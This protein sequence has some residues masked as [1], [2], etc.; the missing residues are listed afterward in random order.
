M[1]ENSQEKYFAERGGNDYFQRNLDV[2]E[3]ARYDHPALELL[4]SAAGNG[5][6]ARGRATVVGGAGGRE[7][8]ARQQ[9]FPG[10]KVSNVDISP[11]A[12]AFG[13]A[14][15]PQVEHHC[16]SITSS[17]PRL[18][19]VLGENDLLFV[20]VVLSWVDRSG[21]SRA[22]ANI[23]ESIRD[24]GLLLISDFFPSTRRRNPIRHAPENFTYKQ[25]YAEPFLSLGIYETVAVSTNTAAQPAELD[26][27]ERRDATHLL[28]K[29]LVGLYPAG[30]FS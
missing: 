14:T 27:Q 16:L 15:F 18:V 11:E 5:L 24:G 6:P 22:I 1:V 4:S 12:I 26:A 10:W 29:D 17:S 21:L 8:A 20:V 2:Q 25:D 13:R 9:R 7:A 3:A 30:R 28:R 23:D 19:E